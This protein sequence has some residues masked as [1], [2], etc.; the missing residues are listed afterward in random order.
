MFNKTATFTCNEKE[1]Y[2]GDPKDYYCDAA[3]VLLPVYTEGHCKLG[4]YVSFATTGDS[5]V[6]TVLIYTISRLQTH[7]IKI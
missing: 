5:W 4:T 2:V 7:P 1:C 6:T 3:G